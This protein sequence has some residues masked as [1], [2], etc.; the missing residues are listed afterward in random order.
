MIKLNKSIVCDKDKVF[1]E[2]VII[3]LFIIPLYMTYFRFKLFTYSKINWIFIGCIL[4]LI[5]YLWK[6]NISKEKLVNYSIAVLASFMPLIV[7]NIGMDLCQNAKINYT[8]IIVIIMSIFFLMNYKLKL[9]KIDYILICYLTTVVI[10][11]VFSINIHNSIFGKFNRYE[12]LIAIV[13][14]VVLYYITSKAYKF[15][16]ILFNTAIASSCIVAFY[17]ICQYYGFDP[18]NKLVPNGWRFEAYSTIGHRNF[19]GSYLTL[20]LPISIFA[21]IKSKNYMYL[22]SSSILFLCMLCIY[23]RSAWLAFMFYTFVLVF[24]IFKYKLSKKNLIYVYTTFAIIFLVFNF[25]NGNKLYERYSS[26]NSDVKMLISTSDGFEHG[27]SG[28][29]FIW[30]R[31]LKILWSRPLTG[32][33]PDT[34][35]LVFMGKYKNDVKT[36]F[37]DNVVFDKA[38]NEYLNMAITTGIPS[39]MLYVTFV[40]FIIIRA[41]KSISRGNLYMIPI[42]CSI[43]GYLLQAFFNIS[44]VSVAP[45]YWIIL[46]IA[47]NLSRESEKL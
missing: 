16:K 32:S 26:I 6:K 11:T 22:I 41:Y 1:N 25:Q 13:V 17:G 46:G 20:F 19:L 29:V 14:Y 31:T 30:D 47:Y 9:E 4:Y 37:G 34:F 23:T 35:D 39:L 2:V 18:L 21:F 10:S 44:V 43:S 3:L 7:M 15:N 38:H 33:G 36:R 8:T 5:F 12:G 27:G 45:I 28:R 40:T 42:L 24:F